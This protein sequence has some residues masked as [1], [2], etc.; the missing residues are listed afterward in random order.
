M[1]VNDHSRPSKHTGKMGKKSRRK[2]TIHRDDKGPYVWENYFVRGKQKRQKRRV[3]VIDG[4]IIDDPD[5]WLLSNA[6]DILLH[7]IER[8]DLAGRREL[9][10]QKPESERIM[11]PPPRILPLT[12]HELESAFEFLAE[13]GPMF[14]DGPHSAFLDLTT[15]AV[16]SPDPE[17]DEEDLWGDENLLALPR[18]L[19]EGLSYGALDEFVHALPDDP[20][21]RELAKAIRGKGAFRRFKDIVFGGGNVELKHR[22]QWFETCRKRE[23]IVDWLRSCNIE[24]EWNRDIFEAPPLPDKRADLLLAVLDFVR[25]ARALTGVRRIAL[26]GSL[27]TSKPIPKDVDLLVEVEDSMALDHLARFK[28]K[29]LGKTMQTGDGCGAEVFLCNPYGEYL[30]RI[31]SWKQCAPGIRQSCLAQHCG[32][33][34]YLYDDLQSVRLDSSV[35]AEPPLELWP[36]LVARVELPDDVR[37]VLVEPLR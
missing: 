12:I 5:E 19:Y 32:Q 31:C 37:E 7:Q 8:W 29:L 13:A 30:G 3:T 11:K 15:G 9:D 21:R 4:K 17:E 20:L 18:D 27:T 16:V 24:P 2:P 23:R 10:D 34:Q 6:D 25:A 14:D 1:A 35:V 33:R 36:R 28:R 26:L 22:W